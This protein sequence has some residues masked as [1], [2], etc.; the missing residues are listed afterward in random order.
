[1]AGDIG[2]YSECDADDGRVACRH[3]VHA[4]VE[5]RTVADGGDDK[6]H[7][8]H[9]DAPSDGLLVGAGPRCQGSVVEIVVL[10]EGNSGLRAFDRLALVDY[11][12][13]LSHTLR[14]DILANDG[15]RTQIQGKP[16]GQ[17]H[18]SLPEE[19]PA[20]GKALFVLLE[21]LDVVVKESQGTEP[22]GGDNHDEEVNVAEAPEEND[23]NECGDNDDDSTHGGDAHLAQSEGVDAGIACRLTDMHTAHALDVFFAEPHGNDESEYECQQRAER[24]KAPHGRTGD[25]VRLKESEKIVQ[26]IQLVIAGDKTEGLYSGKRHREGAMEAMWTVYTRP[27]PTA[28]RYR[29]PYGFPHGRR[30]DASHP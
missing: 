27:P 15:I 22:Y 4:V 23:R 29:K 3:A 1:M 25:A 28:V 20:S 9:K 10:D 13:G 19:F 26:H 6:E 24:N 21:N 17:P 12:G 14:L 5:V 18:K 2:Q 11:L 16:Y 8:Q 7:H 30:S